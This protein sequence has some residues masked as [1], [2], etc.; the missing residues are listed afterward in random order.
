MRQAVWWSAQVL[1]LHKPKQL[2]ALLL[3]NS[4]IFVRTL[5]RQPYFE[6]IKTY[7]RG[8]ILLGLERHSPGRFMARKPGEP[9]EQNHRY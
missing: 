4:T 9:T 8:S 2:C 3:A 7:V 6:R 1:T 5:Y